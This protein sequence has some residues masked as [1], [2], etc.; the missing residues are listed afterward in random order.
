[1]IFKGIYIAI[2]LLIW[3]WIFRNYKLLTKERISEEETN[4]LVNRLKL[5]IFLFVL[6]F[7]VG[8]LSM[9]FT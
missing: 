5:G 7:I 3:F 2:F 9:I 6:Q 8:V 1:M 4:Y